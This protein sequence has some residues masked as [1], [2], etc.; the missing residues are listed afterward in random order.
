M[1]QT[2]QDAAAGDALLTLQATHIRRERLM[3][4]ASALMLLHLAARQDHGKAINQLP[5]GGMQ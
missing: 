5:N 4:L 3:N 2:A 1:E